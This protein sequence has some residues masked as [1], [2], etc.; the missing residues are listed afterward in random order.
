MAT[1]RP[2]PERESGAGYGER[3]F[4]QLGAQASACLIKKL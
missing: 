3:A 4:D 1:R 2:Q